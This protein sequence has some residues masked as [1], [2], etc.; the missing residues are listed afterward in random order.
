MVEGPSQPPTFQ[1]QASTPDLSTPDF[2]TMNFSAPD[3]STMNFW[4]MG[5]F[6][7][8]ERWHFN[9]G[10]FNHEL[11]NPM[12]Q[13]WLKSSWLKSLGLKGPGLKLGIKKS[14][15][16]MSFNHAVSL[17]LLRRIN[18][19]SKFYFRSQG[20]WVNIRHNFVQERC[21]N[22]SYAGKVGWWANHSLGTVKVPFIY[23]V[24]TFLG[25]KYA[26]IAIFSSP[27]LPLT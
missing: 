18:P 2:S 13:K 21:I 24:S 1:P 19:E 14:G 15:V 12:V 22:Y 3:F 5:S 25:L 8:L 7:L 9:S 16:E 4:A 26:N 27:Y 11:F 10:L 6:N 17:Y 20:N 23:Y